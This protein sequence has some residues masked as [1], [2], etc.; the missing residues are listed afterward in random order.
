MEGVRYGRLRLGNGSRALLSGLLIGLA[1]QSLAPQST[2]FLAC[3]P[4]FSYSV[5]MN[6]KSFKEIRHSYPDEFLILIEPEEKRID[7]RWIEITGAQEVY[8]Y[9]SGQEMLDS[10]RKLKKEG[11]RVRFC[12]PNYKESFPVEQI[13]AL[14]AL[15][16]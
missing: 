8:A 5:V 4:G 13:P 7:Q 11:K 1:P 14:G 9:K 15:G 16:R 12:T 2:V 10:Y 6:F 3:L